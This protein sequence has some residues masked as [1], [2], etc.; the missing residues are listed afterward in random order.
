VNRPVGHVVKTACPLDCPD[1]CSLEVSLENGRI[2]ALDGGHGNPVTSGYICG[3]V[4][5]FGDRVYGADRLMRPGLRLGPPGSGEFK[6]VSWDEALGRVVT[7]MREARERWG[8]ESVL[9][10]YYGGSNGLLTQ[11]TTDA[12]LFRRF[13]AS[14]LARTIC[15]STTSA[16][17][18]IWQA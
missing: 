2:V 15:A 6:W 10:Y 14:R 5:R 17:N 3:K 9:P 16:A 7:A 8:A 13:G 12:R 11:D 1:S 4:R 18:L